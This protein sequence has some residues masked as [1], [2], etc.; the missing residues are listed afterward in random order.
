MEEGLTKNVNV[1][2]LGLA[3]MLVFAGFQTMGNVQPIILDSARNQ[4]SDGYVPGFS[5]D[6]FT[7][8]A[9]I[10]AVFTFANWIAPPIVSKIGPRF[11]LIGG[12][13]CYAA[14]IA[15]LIYPNDILLYGCSALIGL[16]AAL[17]WVAQGNFLTI[18]SGEST[19]ERNSGIFWAM[20]QCSLL[21]GNTYVYFVFRG[22][23]DIGKSL[24]TT[25]AVVLL[26]ITSVGVLTF[27]FLRPTPW[28]TS[29]S[30]ASSSPAQILRG[31]FKLLVT[32][33]M[34][35]L[36][37]TFAYT[38]LVLTFWSGVYGTCIGRTKL[39]GEDAKSLVGLHG[40]VVGVGEIVGGLAFGI[41]GQYLNKYIGRTP[42]VI[43]GFVLH[44]TAFI[45]ALI[46]LPFN[47]TMS[48]TNDQAIIEVNASLAIFAS[49]LLGL[50]D[51]CYNTQIYAIIGSLYSDNSA[52]AFAIF[53][54]VQSGLAAV[55]FFYSSHL[56]LQWQLLFLAIFSIIGT[57]TF[58]AVDVSNQRRTRG[59]QFEVVVDEDGNNEEAS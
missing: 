59:D 4:T 8:A 25:V 44:I 41:F 21:I 34:L 15:Q 19:M 16:G 1:G 2:L 43:L 24:R 53:K 26:S 56:Q 45:I 20:L 27:L 38:G 30:A 7:S 10:Y 29:D 17:I 5:G 12:G 3:F 39:F 54:F 46:N 18:N 28:A 49:F 33:G 42:R 55:S 9:I 11:T 57:S 52:P 22:E 31:S 51:A 36:V 58:I 50:G 35:L 13:I 47:S 23:N 48:D 37:L 14:F 6:G 32:P 40:I